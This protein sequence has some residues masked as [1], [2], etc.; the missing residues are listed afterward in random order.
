MKG[1]NVSGVRRS[2]MAEDIPWCFSDEQLKE[3]GV[4][5]LA[6]ATLLQAEEAAAVLGVRLSE[7]RHSRVLGEPLLQCAD[8][9]GSIRYALGEV[10]AARLTWPE[11]CLATA[12]S[13]ILSGR[14]S[15]SVFLARAGSGGRCYRCPLSSGGQFA[16]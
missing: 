11:T 2:G 9:Q 15:V 12:S 7:L 1:I 16:G 6:P 14:A 5:E 13:P 4:F 10:L 3:N 8:A